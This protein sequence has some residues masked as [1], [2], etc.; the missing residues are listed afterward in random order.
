MIKFK[1]DDKEYKVPEVMTI[2][3][4]SKIFKI[5]ELFSEE[6]FTA[7]LVSIITGAPIEDLL[8]GDYE[9]I[10]FIAGQILTLIPITKPEFKDRFELDGVQYGFFPNWKD[11]TY[12]EFVDIDT[13]STKK[14][15]EMLNML[16][17]LCAVM[18]RPITEERSE[19]DFDIEKY[20][21]KTMIKRSELF[22][23]K[24]DVRYVL[25]A[26][27]FFTKF[28]RR[29]LAYSQAS[30]IPKMT[31]WNKIKLTWKMRRIIWAAIFNKPLDGMSSQTELLEMI[32]QST[33]I[34]TKKP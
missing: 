20:D 23:N 14:Q 1:I 13:I 28:G 33:S 9:Q 2:D 16:H 7:K 12:A 15:D 4:Y 3:A 32:L 11:L 30:L 22:K 18:Y 24:L 10:N 25:G 17:V 27:S 19:H 21:V 26:Q 8:E 5:K 34:S 31:R 6:Y 29:Y